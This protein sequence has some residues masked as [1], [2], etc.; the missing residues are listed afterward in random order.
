VEDACQ[1]LRQAKA[2]GADLALLPEIFALQNCANWVAEAEP[3]DGFVITA[4]QQ[5]ARRLNMGLAAGHALVING[6]KH[7]S[8]VL[9]G[10]GGDL[11]AIYHKAYPTINELEKAIVPG[12]GAQ[13]VDTEFG[14]LGFAICYDLNFAELRLA[15]RDLHPDLIL[16]SSFFRG[17]LQTRWWACETRSHLVSSCLDPECVIVNPVGRVLARTDFHTRTAT[18]TLNL[19]CEVL[20]YDYTNLRLAEAIQRHGADL[21]FDWA[22]PEGVFLLSSKGPRPVREILEE[23]GWERVEAYFARARQLRLDALGGQAIPRGK[24]AW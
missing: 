22:E 12:P 1:L 9:I 24:P 15:Y 6:R 13:V 21:D 4:L 5:E 3:L 14:R 17:G 10:R 7:N 23:F 11:Q 16:F 19:D 20:H 8:L 18:A 2:E